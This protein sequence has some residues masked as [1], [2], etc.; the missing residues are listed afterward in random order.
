RIIAAT[1]KDLMEEVKKGNF[2]EDLYYR[3][4]GLTIELP[5]LRTREN[6]IILIAKH[7]MN[8]FCKEN[9]MAAAVLSKSAQQ[10]LL[11]HPFPGNIRELKSCIELAVV[12]C[13]NSQIED[14]DIQFNSN[15]SIKALLTEEKKL[16]EYEKEIIR[17]FLEKYNHNIIT[18]ADKLGIGKSTIYRLLKEEPEFFNHVDR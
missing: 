13:N 6:D 12:M 3:L 9:N 7:F 16:A 5:P 8:N 17:H 10:K 18:V 14:S 4:Y 11:Q 1:N 2:R 15:F